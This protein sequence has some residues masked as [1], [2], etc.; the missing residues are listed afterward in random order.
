MLPK[1]TST[2]LLKSEH[3]HEQLAL[4]GVPTRA[5]SITNPTMDNV[6]KILD[7]K[8]VSYFVKVVF[9]W[10][11]I[12]SPHQLSNLNF[13][14]YYKQNQSK[15]QIHFPKILLIRPAAKVEILLKM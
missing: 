15:I 5:P 3:T 7:I 13:V 4:A 11:L 14:T 10:S 6:K 9:H 8:W 1:F 2:F 12:R